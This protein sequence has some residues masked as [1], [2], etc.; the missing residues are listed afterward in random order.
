MNDLANSADAMLRAR[1]RQVIP[2]GLWGHLNAANLPEG[3]PQFFASAEGC[4]LR[5]ADGREF[6]DFMCGWGPMVVGYRNPVVEDAAR[7]QAALGEALVPFDQRVQAAMQTIRRSRA[8]TPVQLRWL[9]R[10]GKQLRH[11]L[12]LDHAFVNDAFATD[13]GAKQLDKLLGGQLDGVMDQLA[14]SLW[15]RAA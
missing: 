8:W 5:D 4:R 9:D 3:Y 14:E 13:G 10:L 6:I 11:E 12:V 7:R 1:A 15:P 2:G